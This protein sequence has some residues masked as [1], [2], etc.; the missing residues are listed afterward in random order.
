MNTILTNLTILSKA[1]SDENRLKI[2][3]QVHKE[4][5]KC[6]LN[7]KGQ[8]EDQTCINDLNKKLNISLPTVSHHVKELVNAGLLTTKKQGRWSYLQINPKRFKELATFLSLF[9]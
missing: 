9:K 8:C 4:N 3:L 5:L 1:L 6:M 7:K 2:L